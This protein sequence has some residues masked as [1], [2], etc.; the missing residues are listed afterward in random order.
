MNMNIEKNP[1]ETSSNWT[2]EKLKISLGLKKDAKLFYDELKKVV[3]ELGGELYDEK[4]FY[5][6]LH[7]L[8]LCLLFCPGPQQR[9]RSGE[10]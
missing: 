3:Y 4:D 7:A 10:D 2:E 8:G 9:R 5:F 1:R 6:A